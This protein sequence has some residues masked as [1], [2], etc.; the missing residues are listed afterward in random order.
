[1]SAGPDPRVDNQV[2]EQERRRLSR[3]LDEVARMCEANLPAATFYGELLKRLLEIWCAGQL[4]AIR[5]DQ[6]RLAEMVPVMEQAVIRHRSLP[7]FRAALALAYC[8]A[9][10]L[11]DARAVLSEAMAHA[12]IDVP[13]DMVWTTAIA[14]HAEPH[15]SPSPAPA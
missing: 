15:P 1:M 13:V 2:I 9:G 3:R 11:D 12:F 5:W 8:E 4:V 14:S 10:R 7:A 6:G